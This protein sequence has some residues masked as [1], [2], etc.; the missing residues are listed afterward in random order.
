MAKLNVI[1]RMAVD[2]L[3]GVTTFGVSVTEDLGVAVAQRGQFE[4]RIEEKFE[5]IGPDAQAAVDKFMTDHAVA[6]GLA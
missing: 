1:N 4:I 6:L 5:T 3:N 2:H